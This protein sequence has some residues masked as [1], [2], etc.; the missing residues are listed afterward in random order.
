MEVKD[1]GYTPVLRERSLEDKGD[2]LTPKV[3]TD[4]P[5]VLLVP[6][7]DIPED[8]V[9]AIQAVTSIFDF[10]PFVNPEEPVIVSVADAETLRCILKFPTLFG[11][12]FY[13]LEGVP[14]FEY[15]DYFTETTWGL[16]KMSY[17]ALAVDV[18]YAR[19]VNDDIA[20]S[21]E[22]VHQKERRRTRRKSGGQKE[23]KNFDVETIGDDAIETNNDAELVDKDA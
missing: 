3:L 16:P 17:A 23:F 6:G 21:R 10:E 14:G 2:A 9:L 18:T 13:V 15:R 8:G 12:R 1:A 7:G 5:G 22:S 4:K 19:K 20:V 11:E